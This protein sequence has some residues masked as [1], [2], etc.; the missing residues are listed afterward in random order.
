MDDDAARRL[1]ASQPV[2]VFG[3]VTPAGT[4]HL[5]PVT[6]ALPSATTIVHAI[7]HKPK[8]TRALKRLDNVRDNPAVS[9]L[10]HAYHADWQR[11]W[12]VRADAEATVLTAGDARNEV[13]V[14]ALRRRY[15]QYR[16]RAPGG[17][18][19]WC[20]VRRWTGWTA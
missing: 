11:L 16:A 2:A 14:A 10:A 18:V 15:P 3:S 20:Q 7:D 19:V 5:V 8:S 12:W 17:P 4:P 9:L 13:A 1:F 6:F